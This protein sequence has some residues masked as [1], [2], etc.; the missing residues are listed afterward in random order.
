[1]K[2]NKSRIPELLRY[3]VSILFCNLWRLNQLNQ[4][5]E[6]AT[7]NFKIKILMLMLKLGY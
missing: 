7:L 5:L 6:L 3:L 2:Q 4:V 1:M